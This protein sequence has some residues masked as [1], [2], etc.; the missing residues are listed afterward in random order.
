MKNK[1]EFLQFED[2]TVALVK[3]ECIQ[4]LIDVL[5]SSWHEIVLTDNDETRCQATIGLWQNYLGEK[6]PNV[7][8]QFQSRLKNVELLER[9]ENEVKRYSLLYSMADTDGKCIYYEGRN[10]MDN[11]LERSELE[12]WERLPMGIRDFYENVHDGFY[13]YMNRGMGLQPLRFT[14]FFEVVDEEIAEW[15]LEVGDYGEL[16]TEESHQLA[17]YWNNLGVALSMD[18]SENCEKNAVLWKRDSPP[19]F[20]ADFWKIVDQL[21]ICF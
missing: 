15:N 21:L 12:Y 6:L 4:E 18:D 19:Q 13:H 17:F 2:S 8:E 5:P 20:K 14:H 7:L 11:V 3:N 16:W 9:R 10:P 1:L